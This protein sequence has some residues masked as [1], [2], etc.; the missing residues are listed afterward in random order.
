MLSLKA[1]NPNQSLQDVPPYM[2][3]L[4]HVYRSAN[5]TKNR[6]HDKCFHYTGTNNIELTFWRKFL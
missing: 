2:H 1:N 6:Y 5:Y 4:Q 3:M